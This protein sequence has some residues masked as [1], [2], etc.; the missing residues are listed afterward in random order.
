MF[1]RITSLILI[2]AMMMSMTVLGTDTSATVGEDRTELMYALGIFDE[3]YMNGIGADDEITRGK[4]AQI[5]CGFAG[6]DYGG[7][8][9]VYSD[10]ESDSEYMG[11]VASVT[12]LGIMDGYTDGKFRPESKLTVIQAVKALIEILNLRVY[13]NT[14]GGY[15]NGYM[16]T[17][18]NQ[19][20]LKGVSKNADDTV[21]AGEFAKMIYNSFDSEYLRPT[22]YGDGV[23]YEEGTGVLASLLDIYTAEGVLEA[24][25]YTSLFGKEKQSEGYITIGGLTLKAVDMGE[26][27]LGYTVRVYYKKA[28]GMES[29]EALYIESKNKNITLC[30]DA[31]DISDETNTRNFI[32]YSND[33]RR[34]ASLTD[35]T[36]VIING[37]RKT[38][39]EAA[40]LK[41]ASGK[42]T[43]IDANAD[44]KFETARIDAYINVLIDT[45]YKENGIYTIS[46]ARSGYDPIKIDMSGDG[47]CSVKILGRDKDFQIFEKDSIITVYADNLNVS[48]MKLEGKMSLCRIYMA[49]KERNISIKKITKD[50]ITDTEGKEYEF[51]PLFDADKAQ[52]SPG[53]DVLIR[54]DYY[55]KVEYVKESR[56]YKYAFLRNAGSDDAFGSEVK[57]RMFTESNA[58]EDFVISDKIT[59][60]NKRYSVTDARAR[61]KATA[62]EYKLKTGMSMQGTSG[63]EQLLRY[64]TNGD[65]KL[66]ELDTI[67]ANYSDPELEK[68]CFNLRY[69]YDVNTVSEKAYSSFWQGTVK[70]SDFCLGIDSDVV[71][72]FV[73]KDA[74]D[75]ESYSIM[76][77][78]G[79]ENLNNSASFFD[80]DDMDIV[81]AFVK[82]GE[83][84]STS[85]RENE[86]ANL[87]VVGEI[88]T[89]INT[90]G[91]SVKQINGIALRSGAQQAKVLKSEDILGDINIEAG[92]IISW[93]EDERGRIIALRKVMSKPD[94]D[95]SIGDSADNLL[96]NSN[97]HTSN[98][99]TEGLIYARPVK[100]DGKYWIFTEDYASGN[101]YMQILSPLKHTYIF[102]SKSRT[103]PVTVSSIDTLK[104]ID[105]YGLE[106]SDKILILIYEY[107]I[108]SVLIYR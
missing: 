74:A 15:P 65:G 22:G 80:A 4:A 40:D 82:Y 24:N 69:N 5:L 70:F 19:G 101:S 76:K 68:N 39:Y 20:I 3:S 96:N 44:G 42:V 89:T 46:D 51:S 72:F 83:K 66:T 64:Y 54:L 99:T 84:L 50:G 102:D 108:Y 93:N 49:K 23:T 62:A 17:A 32:Y 53:R 87:M 98:G 45:A 100:S 36:N 104:T 67:C 105:S 33:K 27:L 61:L 55:D 90:E 57:L 56:K 37:K 107:R 30:V 77:N 79:Q 73:P 97:T 63:F 21:T 8:T 2:F 31:E 78:E 71:Y 60:D 94:K 16:F 95:G 14:A 29:G 106:E 25:E 38:Y 47:T 52:L 34:T 12:A 28:R 48:S 103:Y 13:A 7:S 91:D 59:I 43:L 9:D 85:V 1:K 11:A 6:A 18:V 58:F 92:D 35:Y 41:P 10:I 81:S 75:T 88:Q 26:E 86:T